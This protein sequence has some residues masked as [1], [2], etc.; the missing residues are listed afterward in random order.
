MSNDRANDGE[1][2]T[3]VLE[4]QQLAL[5]MQFYVDFLTGVL[6]ISSEL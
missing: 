3:D 6:W 1:P 5:T 4:L 2:L